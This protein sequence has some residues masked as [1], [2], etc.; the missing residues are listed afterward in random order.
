MYFNK[1]LVMGINNLGFKVGEVEFAQL[2]GISNEEKLFLMF[3][4][5]RHMNY[6][7]DLRLRLAAVDDMNELESVKL[8]GLV[9]LNLVDS[10]QGV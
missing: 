2:V 4:R 1:L 8:L 3:D 10:E 6:I 5:K 9:E 7:A